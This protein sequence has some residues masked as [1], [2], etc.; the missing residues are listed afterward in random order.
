MGVHHTA[1]TAAAAAG[2]F[3]MSAGAALAQPYG[4]GAMYHWGYGWWPFGM[5]LWPVLSI[6]LVLLFVWALWS[7]RAPHVVAGAPRRSSGLDVLEERYARGEIGR[8]EYL[9]KKADIR[10]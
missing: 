1:V 6:A 2:A 9:Q 7:P 3:A 5:V 4:P 10:D 8:D